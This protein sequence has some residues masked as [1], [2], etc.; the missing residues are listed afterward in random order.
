M[1]R[2]CNLCLLENSNHCDYCQ[3]GLKY[4]EYPN[5][6]YTDMFKHHL[7][8]DILEMKFTKVRNQK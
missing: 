2:I 8:H 4:Q 6:T 7:E 5:K 3:Y 1:N